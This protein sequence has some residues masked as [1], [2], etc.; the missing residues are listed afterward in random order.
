M[1]I[2]PD[3]RF[4]L[5]HPAHVIALGLGSGLAA[6]APGTFGTLAALPLYALWLALGL[7]PTLLA[8]LLPLLFALGCWAC[9]RTGDALGAPDHGAM[10]W[11]EMVA[12][13]ALLIVLPATPLAWALGFA[14][15]RVFDIVKPWPIRWLDAQL[16]GGFGV[17]LDDA[18]AALLPLPAPLLAALGLAAVFAGAANT[19]LA[20]TLLAIELFGG[21]IGLFAALACA[22][23]Y[24]CSGHQGIYRAQRLEAPKHRPA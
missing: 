10:V 11:D 8:W 12:M 24:A 19:P 4:M 5:R 6:K 17:M 2:S 18:L 20:C 21:G 14:L 1:T 22:A 9:Q 7:S 13:W 3:W 15:F 16:K 23:S